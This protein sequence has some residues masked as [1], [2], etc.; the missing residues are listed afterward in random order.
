MQRR[1]PEPQVVNP[2]YETGGPIYEEIPGEKNFNSLMKQPSLATPGSTTP[3]SEYVT[4]EGRI[5]GETTCTSTKETLYFLHRSILTQCVSKIY[6]Q[7]ENNKLYYI[8]KFI[9]RYYIKH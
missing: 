7:T 9:S 1:L 3:G 2:L 8:V 6:L 5:N 4:M